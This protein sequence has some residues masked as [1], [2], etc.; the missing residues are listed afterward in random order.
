M[1]VN[2]NFFLVRFV[3]SGVEKLAWEAMAT[4]MSDQRRYR[5]NHLPRYFLL[6]KQL[7]LAKA[8]QARAQGQGQV[9]VQVQVQARVRAQT[10]QTQYV[11]IAPVPS[12]TA[13]CVR[14]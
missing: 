6:L 9:Q 1:F 7:T 2:N 12:S 5:L 3:L 13:Y 4:I 11:L 10:N 14:E 8:A